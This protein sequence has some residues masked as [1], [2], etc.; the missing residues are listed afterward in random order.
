MKRTLENCS[1]IKKMGD[2]GTSYPEQRDG[3]CSGYCVSRDNDE[4]CDVCKN[5]K[6]NEYYEEDKIE[7]ANFYNVRQVLL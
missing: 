1:L 3:K 5:C 7:R 2:R 4:P 6:L